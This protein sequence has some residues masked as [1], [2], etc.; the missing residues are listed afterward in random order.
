MAIPI[1]ANAATVAFIM[2][3]A[4]ECTH[5]LLFTKCGGFAKCRQQSTDTRMNTRMNAHEGRRLKMRDF[6]NWKC[7]IWAKSLDHVHYDSCLFCLFLSATLTLFWRRGPRENLKI[8]FFSLYIN[9]FRLSWQNMW[10]VLVSMLMFVNLLSS[11]GCQECCEVVRKIEKKIFWS[12][13]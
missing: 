4:A 13:E 2:K 1:V 11:E 8:F 12:L 3:C 10:F 5:P 9:L 6:C 7:G